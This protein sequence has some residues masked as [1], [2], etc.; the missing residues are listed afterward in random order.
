MGRGTTGMCVRFVPA[1]LSNK[2]CRVTSLCYSGDSKE[3]LVSYSSDYIYLFD[4]VDDQARELKGP[5]EERREEVS[6]YMGRGTT[7]MCV[8][9]VPAH[10]SNK[11]CRVTSLCYS[12]DS[13]EAIPEGS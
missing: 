6:N 11:S 2:S 10:L 7:G 9:F 13:K 4:P 12:G 5:S 3:V 8:R 1:H